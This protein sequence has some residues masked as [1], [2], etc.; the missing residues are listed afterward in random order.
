MASFY[1]LIY[2]S[3]V[4]LNSSTVQIYQGLHFIFV[5]ALVS[6]IVGWVINQIT[7]KL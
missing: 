6:V 2:A 5:I 7:W 3:Q 1:G 4:N